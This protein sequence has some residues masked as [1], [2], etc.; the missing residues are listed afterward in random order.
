M[1][2][3][4]R[5]VP[6]T[7]IRKA[8]AMPVVP[9]AEYV[10]YW[11]VANRRRRFNF[12][13]QHAVNWAA[14]LRKPLLV[15]E[16]LNCDYPWASDR[17]HAF[18]VGGMQSNAKAF[19]GTAASYIPLV[20]LAPRDVGIHEL[21]ADAS[22]VVTDDYP[23]FVIPKWTETMAS[24]SNVLV[25]CVDGSGLLPFRETSRT[26]QTAH[27]FRRFL[28][29][30]LP[31]ELEQA[32]LADSLDGIDLPKLP[33]RIRAG[34]PSVDLQRRVAVDHSVGEIRGLEGG[35]AAAQRRLLEF[36]DTS[37]MTYAEGHNKVEAGSSSGLSPYLHFGH[38]SVHDVFGE[39][40]RRERWHSGRLGAKSN[41][42]RVG[43]WG[44]RADTEAFLDQIV[45]WR[46]LGFNRCATDPVFDQFSSLP[47]WALRTLEKHKSDPRKH[48]YS[49]D[50]FEGAATHDPLWNAAQR[51]LLT[52]GTIHNYL[53]MLWGKKILEWSAAPEDALGVMIQLNNKF[54]LDGRDPNSYSGI[55]WILGRYDRPWGPERPIFGTVRYMSSENTARKLNVRSYLNRFG[56]RSA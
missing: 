8:N 20:Q 38:L 41:G 54:A 16:G 19:R 10:L 45:T 39:L 4:E 15:V 17:I 56:N 24:R 2:T 36:L 51:E 40:T 25:E 23:A 12:A 47:D 49:L 7:R 55:F 44:M 11:M 37:L 33:K 30:R 43:W 6:Q 14:E 48:S 18:V 52:T 1:N 5:S 27:S 22:I 50:D 31:T 46:E 32:P 42:S 9:S 28:Q 21:T 26:F 3:H 13:L 34:L 35:E 29:T 53:R